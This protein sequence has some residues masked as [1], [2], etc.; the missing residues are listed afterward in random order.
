VD[1]VQPFAEQLGAGPQ[2]QDGL[3]PGVGMPGVLWTPFR[4]LRSN[5]SPTVLNLKEVVFLDFVRKNWHI[6]AALA[7]VVVLGAVY[8][9]RM[10]G[11]SALPER[12]VLNPVLATDLPPAEQEEQSVVMAEELAEP[13]EIV[14]HIEGAVNNPGVYAVSEGSRVNDLLILAGGATD[15]ADLS[16]VNLAAFLQDAQQII[17]PIYGE[18]FVQLEQTTATGQGSGGSGLVNINTADAAQLTTLPGVG[19]VI[20]NNII[21]HREANGP[22]ATIEQLTNVPRIGAATLANLREFIT[23]N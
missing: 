18:E 10:G 21:A 14:V 11:D 8:L 5:Q 12:T 16:R 3:V 2:R 6:L 15:E 23:V 4:R 22:F 20:A 17:I 13:V 1:T 9:M 19:A 7:V